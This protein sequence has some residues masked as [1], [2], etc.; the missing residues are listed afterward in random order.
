MHAFWQWCGRGAAFVGVLVLYLLATA[1]MTPWKDTHAAAWIVGQCLAVASVV[2]CARAASGPIGE[3]LRWRRLP[4]GTES[5]V[6]PWALWTMGAYIV[7]SATCALAWRDA[8]RAD[9]Y[10]KLSTVIL[11][12]PWSMWVATGLLAP[13]GEELLFRGVGLTLLGEGGRRAVAVTGTALL[14]AAVHVEGYKLLPIA[15]LGFV[16]ARVAWA[17]RSILPSLIA[18]IGVNTF[19]VVASV[20]LDRAAWKPASSSA[21]KAPT[22]LLAILGCI[23]AFRAWRATRQLE[24]ACAVADRRRDEAESAKVVPI[25]DSHTGTGACLPG[26][27]DAGAG[28]SPGADPRED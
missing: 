16:F 14:F 3:V 20:G 17:T 12:H 21:G 1:S 25:A 8:G 26:D 15:L 19:A 9:A 10:S 18:H 23:L 24:A 22:I 6:A 11:A 27:R 13:L 4:G 28:A 5:W 7:V 2:V